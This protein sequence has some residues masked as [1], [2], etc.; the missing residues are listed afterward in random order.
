MEETKKALRA[1]LERIVLAP[2]AE[3][4]EKD[5]PLERDLAGLVPLAAGAQGPNADKVPDRT[6]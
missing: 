4:P 5:L 6:P 3:D 2:A 1:L